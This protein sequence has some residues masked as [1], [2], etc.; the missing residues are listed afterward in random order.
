M[1]M[2]GSGC[3]QYRKDLISYIGIYHI[4]TCLVVLERFS[5]SMQFKKI[6]CKAI[7]VAMQHITNVTNYNL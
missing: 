2:S 5:F 6:L 3:F 1:P 7:H 4:L